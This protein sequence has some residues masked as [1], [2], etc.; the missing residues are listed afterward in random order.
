MASNRNP[1]RAEDDLVDWF[2]IT[3]KSIF[4]TLG[5]VLLAGGFVY[6]YFFRD[7]PPPPPPGARPRPPSPPPASPRSTAA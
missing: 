4:L 7:P 1:R 5:A 6:V 2:T 3:Y